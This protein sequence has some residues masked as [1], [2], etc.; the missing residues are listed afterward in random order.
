MIC[1]KVMGISKFYPNPVSL[2]CINY[3]HLWFIKF[4]SHSEFFTQGGVGGGWNIE[5]DCRLEQNL[6]MEYPYL[7]KYVFYV[8][9]LWLYMHFNYINFVIFKILEGQTNLY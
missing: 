6:K 8:H 3:F 5:R 9:K 7:E 2:W 4:R 1:Q